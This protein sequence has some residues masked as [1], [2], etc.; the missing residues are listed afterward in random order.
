MLPSVGVKNGDIISL[1]HVSMLHFL[2][3]HMIHFHCMVFI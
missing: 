3:K 1:P 2:I